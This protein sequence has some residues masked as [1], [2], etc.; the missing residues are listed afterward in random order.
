MD[1]VAEL[2]AWISAAEHKAWERKS[3]K[4]NDQDTHKHVQ[5]MYNVMFY[6]D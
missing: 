4:K 2:E 5:R 1:H 6:P 3:R